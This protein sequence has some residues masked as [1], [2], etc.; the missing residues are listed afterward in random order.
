MNKLS[1]PTV[2]LIGVLGAIAVALATLAHW[3]AGAILGMVGILAGIGGGAAVG[4]AVAGK[5]DVVHAE[6]EAQ[7]RTLQKI[8][9]QTNGLSTKEK[10][11]IAEAAAAAVLRQMRGQQQ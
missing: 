5:V 2:G 1:W 11:D 4:G 10:Q 9:R 6:T 7:T 3:E 8:E